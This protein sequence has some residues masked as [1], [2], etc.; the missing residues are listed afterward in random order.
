MP[1]NVKQDQQS[2][3]KAPLSDSERVTQL[4]EKFLKDLNE[5]PRYKTFFEQY[6]ADS[7]KGFK[8]YYAKEKA[9]LHVYHKYQVDQIEHDQYRFYNIAWEKL[10]EIQ[11]RKLFDMQCLWRARQIEIP[12][13]K[14]SYD[15][16]LWEKFVKQ[17]TFLSP[18]SQTEFERYL[19]Y[20]EV[21]SYDDIFQERFFYIQ[22][23]DYE[24]LQDYYLHGESNQDEDPP[25][26]YEY[27]EQVTGYSSYYLLPDIRGELENNYIKFSS[28]KD[29]GKIPDKPNPVTD[30]RPDY[31]YY[32]SYELEK[33]TKQ[34]EEFS[35]KYIRDCKEKYFDIYEDEELNDAVELLHLADTAI[36][37]DNCKNWRESIIEAANAFEK[38]K[39]IEVF[40][41]VYNDYLF[42][43]QNNLGFANDNKYDI[44][45]ENSFNSF[46]RNLVLD[47]RENLGE[48]RDFNF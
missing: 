45:N 29:E 3:N 19:R 16:V 32:L 1:E 25:A 11:Q 34:F 18:I 10:W 41:Q 7:I 17:C 28:K 22:W 4:T 35:T 44:F 24:N 39:V 47:G 9:T 26:W 21:T 31:K 27:Y 6:N 15:F 46:Y 23:Q 38:Q 48:P 40:P 36:H 33:F 14:V 13:I 5:N 43:I 20:F 12:E 8:E 30:T 42:R 37:L 2:E